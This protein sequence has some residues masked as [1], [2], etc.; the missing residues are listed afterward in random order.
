MKRFT[1]AVNTGRLEALRQLI[2]PGVK[3][4]DPAPGQESGPEGYIKM[5]GALREAFPDLMVTA[6]KLVTDED[7]VGMAYT[8]TGT[9][10]GA[11]MGIAATGKAIRAR[12]VQIAR[13][14]NGIL[15]ERWGSS[16]ELGILRQLGAVENLPQP[17]PLR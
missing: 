15:I 5:F 1:Q 14:E 11:F 13:F 12:G 16:D 2:A 9:H 10:R 3:D 6:D 17:K 8:M 4:H 7:Q